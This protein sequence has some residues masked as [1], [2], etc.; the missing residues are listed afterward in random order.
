[1]VLYTF[2][3]PLEGLVVSLLS[4]YLGNVTGITRCLVQQLNVGAGYI[5]SCLGVRCTHRGPINNKV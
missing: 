4:I 2:P 3:A 1:M 5:A